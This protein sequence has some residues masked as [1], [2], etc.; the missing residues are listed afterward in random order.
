MAANKA[1][2]L[3][4]SKNIDRQKSTNKMVRRKVE[5][6]GLGRCDCADACDGCVVG[7]GDDPAEGPAEELVLMASI[8]RQA[9]IPRMNVGCQGSESTLRLKTFGADPHRFPE[10]YKA[11]YLS[12]H[13]AG[14]LL[15]THC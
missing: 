13:Q 1:D 2:R 7:I 5:M 12:Q 4:E 11:L 8:F 9:G 6:R 14:K 10:P 15:R 3:N